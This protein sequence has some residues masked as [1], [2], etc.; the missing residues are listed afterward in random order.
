MLEELEDVRLA[1]GVL[2]NPGRQPGN[3]DGDPARS[4]RSLLRCPR[5]K[6]AKMANTLTAQEIYT[7]I[8]SLPLAERLRLAERVV[9]DAADSA[10]P[11]EPESTHERQRDLDAWSQD[12]EELAR[13][14]PADDFDRLDA[15]LEEADRQAKE[16]VRRQMG[17]T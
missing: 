8:R 12:V 5:R 16:H 4:A 13:Q 15:A 1:E 6:D 3:P 14:I 7:A 9:H 11:G 2:A 10:S 17:L